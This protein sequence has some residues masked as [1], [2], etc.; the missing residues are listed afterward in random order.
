MPASKL[1]QILQLVHRAMNLSVRK[2]GKGSACEHYLGGTPST[3]VYWESEQQFPGLSSVASVTATK[4]D[5][6]MSFPAPGTWFYSHEWTDS[7]AS[8]LKLQNSISDSILIGNKRAIYLEVMRCT[9]VLL[10]KS[11][12]AAQ[13]SNVHMLILFDLVYGCV[14]WGCQINCFQ[15]VKYLMQKNGVLSFQHK[16][17]LHSLD[18]FCPPNFPNHKLNRSSIPPSL[19]GK[20]MTRER[21]HGWSWRA[22]CY[23]K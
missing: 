19:W 22:L 13:L 12:S 9:G 5:L 2:L 7:W 10:W 6:R 3:H 18:N 14:Q 15:N 1:T 20:R 11:H 23:V 21:Q 16:V 4:D 8:Q 17:L